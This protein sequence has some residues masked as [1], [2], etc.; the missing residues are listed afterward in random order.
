MKSFDHTKVAGLPQ[1]GAASR[2]LDDLAHAVDG[3][4][5]DEFLDLVRTMA[6]ALSYSDCCTTGGC[7]DRMASYAPMAAEVWD[8]WVRGIYRCPESH[9]WTCGYAEDIWQY[10]F[11]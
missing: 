10:V 2:A 7:D 11:S 9:V 6:E 1:Y 3:L 5:R 8:G 4:T